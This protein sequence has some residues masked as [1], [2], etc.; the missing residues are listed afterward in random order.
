MQFPASL[1]AETAAHTASALLSPPFGWS[2]ATAL[3]A[4]AL[5]AI[6]R[7][8]RIAGGAIAAGLLA[9]LIAGIVLGPGVLGRV[10]PAFG[11]AALAGNP[12]ILEALRAVEREEATLGFVRGAPVMIGADASELESDLAV[13]RA[14]AEAAWS[15]ERERHASARGLLALAFAGLVLAGSAGASSI[16]KPF[17]YSHIGESV[18]LAAWSIL[19]VVTLLGLTLWLFGIDPFAP[20]SIALGGA[21]IAGSW[22]LTRSDRRIARGVTRD[23]GALVEQGARWASAVASSMTIVAMALAATERLAPVAVA[24]VALACLPL[25]WLAGSLVRASRAASLPALVVRTALPALVAMMML[26]IEP[27]R[28]IGGRGLWLALILYLL[29]EDGRWVGASIAHWAARRAGALGS[30]RLAIAGMASEPM[31]AALVGVGWASGILPGWL[32]GPALLAAT[33]SALLANLRASAADRLAS[34]ES[35]IEAMRA[36]NR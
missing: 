20:A 7:R 28:D 4:I 36:A 12:T 17:R 19:P 2:L 24:L 13:R 23:G 35:E 14:E 26:T 22:G 3:A 6:L 9:G 11:T 25:G 21:V 29:I 31:V 5:A 32:T 27:F 33:G 16:R 8:L 18:M 30:M 34:A 15:A 1:F 10:A